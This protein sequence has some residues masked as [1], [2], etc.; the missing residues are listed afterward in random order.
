MLEQTAMHASPCP[1]AQHMGAHHLQQQ[2][3][4]GFWVLA[5]RRVKGLTYAALACFGIEYLTLFMG[6]TI[7]IR[8]LNGLNI[9][10]HGVGLILTILLYVDV[11]LAC[12]QHQCCCMTAAGARAAV[13]T[14]RAQPH[15]ACA[16]T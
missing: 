9:I 14:G 8:P 12:L 10:A 13:L 5:M 15:Q 7:F 16:S 11:S 3:P 4:S 6:V 2:I 1:D